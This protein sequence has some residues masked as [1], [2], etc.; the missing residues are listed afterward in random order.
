MANLII[1][2]KGPLS[3]LTRLGQE[4][5][6]DKLKSQEEERIEVFGQESDLKAKNWI[7]AELREEYRKEK[8]YFD[9]AV[10]VLGNFK[11]K[12]QYNRF[13]TQIFLHFASQEDIPKRYKI[14]LEV[15]NIGI[16]IKILG[17]DYVGA[18]RASG[19]TSYDF[20][21]CKLMA[22]KLGNTIAKLEGYKRVTNQGVILPDQEDL[23]KFSYGASRK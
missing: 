10:S 7:Q 20:H 8:E 18:F 4:Q 14:D 21:A 3:S 19:L 23:T 5:E 6:L 1:K 2:N 22:V 11:K 17:T 13:L 12:I 9:F 16:I 15:N